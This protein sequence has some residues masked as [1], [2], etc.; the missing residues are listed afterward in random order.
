MLPSQRGCGTR[1]GTLNVPRL[2]PVSVTVGTLTSQPASAHLHR[3]TVLAAGDRPK[4]PC[5]HGARP[6]DLCWP[7]R[8]L[9]S[10]TEFKLWH[11]WVLGGRWVGW[12]G[13]VSAV[14][15]TSVRYLPSLCPPSPVKRGQQCDSRCFQRWPRSLP[16]TPPPIRK[17]AVSCPPV[18]PPL[19]LTNRCRRRDTV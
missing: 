9:V 2:F 7:Q 15:S 3:G 12:C 6:C 14:R 13:F 11:G 10:G 16:L 4:V 8:G 17:G 19:A 1:G 5:P 18:S